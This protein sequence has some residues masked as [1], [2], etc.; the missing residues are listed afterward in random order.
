M[1]DHVVSPEGPFAV[2]QA[3]L[4]E[5][6]SHLLT[7]LHAELCAD[8]LLAL[9]APGKLLSDLAD[10]R[11]VEASTSH[12]LPAGV[13]PLLTLLIAQYLV[14]ESDPLPACRVALA[15]E[16]FICALDLLDDAEDGDATPLI[17]AI[18]V[19]RVLNVSTTLLALAHRAILSLFACEVAP[20]HTLLLLNTLQETSLT[21]TAGQ[22]QDLL[23]EQKPVEAFDQQTCLAIAAGKA[24]ALMRLACLLG[25]L[26]VGASQQLCEQCAALG[27]LLGIAHQLDNDCHDLS[28]ILDNETSP[29]QKAEQYVKT[30]LQRG[31][32]T[33]PVVLAAASRNAYPQ[34]SA[35]Q[36]EKM[37]ES[38]RRALREGILT[39]WGVCLLYRERA[40]DCLQKIA[41]SCARPI[42]PELHLLLGL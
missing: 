32:K 2:Q 13:W 41:D 40:S 37:P 38:E 3:L 27:E 18:G 4:A 14:P 12:R 15:V 26:C 9:R 16:C 39:T 30:D 31:K 22:H 20:E 5:Q 35:S 11:A 25:A 21:A 42:S 8:V 6:F 34:E 7:D 19:P 28:L 24:G 23:A 1:F 29:A 36:S 33:L 17:Q 10:T